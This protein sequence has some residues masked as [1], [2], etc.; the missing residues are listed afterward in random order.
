MD[1]LTELLQSYLNSAQDLAQCAEWLAGVDW[2]DPSLTDGEKETLGLL[3]LLAVEVSEGLRPE[4]DFRDAA[5]AL[6][7]QPVAV[8]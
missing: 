5:A 8:G 7:R 6:T 1:E 4:Q 3:E 2:A